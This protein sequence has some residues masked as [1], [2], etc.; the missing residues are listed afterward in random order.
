VYI[1]GKNIENNIFK[2]DVHGTVHR[3]IFLWK[4]NKMNNF[5]FFEFIEY[6]S[7]FRTVFL[8]III[9]P[10]PYMQRQVY[11]IQVH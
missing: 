2:V 5:F 7:V 9:S 4:T 6:H 1:T 8:F 10:R 3:D 11:V